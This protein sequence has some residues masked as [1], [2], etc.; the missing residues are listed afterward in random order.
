MKVIAVIPARLKSTRLKEKMLKLIAGKPL[1]WYTYNNT[2]RSKVSDVVIATDSTKIKKTLEDLGCKIILTSKKHKSGTDRIGEV[3]KKIYADYYINV[4]G[5]EPL[6]KP[7]ILN[8]II[9]YIRKSKRV[10]IL[11]VAKKIKD[12]SEIENPA[13]VKIVTDKNKNALYFSRAPIPYNR[14]QKTNV[15]YYKHLGIYCYKY[16]VLQKIIKLKQ[17]YLEKIEKLEQL[18]WLENG[19]DI[20]V[21]ETKYDTI[22]VDTEKDFKIVKKIIESSL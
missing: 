2:K 4:Q 10:E 1:V 7:Q 14:E 21:I 3:S 15:N 13:V 20:K 19:F 6:I 16:S 5:D 9:D 11:T 22:S 17:S 8:Q 18:R 12:K